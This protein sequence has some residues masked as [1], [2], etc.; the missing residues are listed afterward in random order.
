MPKISNVG[1]IVVVAVIAALL[2][3]LT[4]VYVPGSGQ[5]PGSGPSEENSQAGPDG[6][7]LTATSPA[8]TLGS[9]QTS[10]PANTNGNAAAKPA[11]NP[12]AGPVIH[13]ITPEGGDTWTIGV[14]NLISWNKPG[15]FTGSLS[16]LDA[17]TSQFVG[18][19]LPSI[20]TNQTSYAWNTR[21]VFLDRSDP[22]K[23]DVVP[24]IYE[25]ELT[26]DGNHIKPAI[27]SP[28]TITN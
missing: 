17:S 26:Y 19:I 13:L 6:A 22:Q 1:K 12:P 28:F 10:T 2:I 20:G 18:T 3:V 25:I 14:Q 8:A 27:S 21:D 4:V 16:L 9:P 15:N 7:T 24:G 11:A 5:N 23:Q